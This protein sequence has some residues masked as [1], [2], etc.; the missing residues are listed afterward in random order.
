MMHRSHALS[1]FIIKHTVHALCHILGASWTRYLESL[2]VALHN[3]IIAPTR[4]YFKFESLNMSVYVITGVSR[5]IGVSCMLC[6]ACHR[7]DWPSLG[8]LRAS[9][10]TRRI[11]S[12]VWF[13]TRLPRNRRL[14]QSWAVVLTSTSF[15]ENSPTMPAWNKP[16]PTLPKLLASAALTTLS[17]TQVSPAILTLFRLLVNCKSTSLCLISKLNG[18]NSIGT[19]SLRSW[20]TSQMIYSRPMSPVI[21]TY[22]TFSCR[23]CWRVRPR[24]SSLSPVAMP[25]LTSSTISTL[26]TLPYTLPPKRRWTPLWPSSAHNTRKTVCSSSAWVQEWWMWAISANVQTST[27]ED[28]TPGHFT[29]LYQ[30]WLPNRPRDW[31]NSWADFRPM[32]LTS[33][34]QSP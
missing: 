25:T 16:L 7:S 8:F 29:D 10:R 24:K 28:G 15:M 12:S 18:I 1:H 22:S 32:R 26:R 11:W 31:R 5:G 30:Q 6:R 27:F 20:T 9:P 3:I 13:V 17:P 23:L 4:T 34:V 14:Q 33:R 2:N 21:S 19:K